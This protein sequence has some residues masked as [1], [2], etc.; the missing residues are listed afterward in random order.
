[1]RDSADNEGVRGLRHPSAAFLAAV[2]PLC[3]VAYATGGTLQRAAQLVVSLAGVAGIVA[4]TRRNRPNAPQAWYSAA[5]ALAVWLAG[6]ALHAWGPGPLGEHLGHLAGGAAYLV[7]V[8]LLTRAAVLAARARSG[9]NAR[10]DLLRAA[11]ATAPIVY[12]T[13]GLLVEDPVLTWLRT[14]AGAFPL[15]ATYPLAHALLLGAFL[16]LAQVPGAGRRVAAIP[17]VVL[18]TILAADLLGLTQPPL[19]A[20]HPV[21]FDLRWLVAYPALGAAALHPAM[22]KVTE[23][24]ARFRRPAHAAEIVGLML[25]PLTGPALLAWQDAHHEELSG[26]AAS[27]FILVITLL[28]G[29][30]MLEMVR[31]INA[32]AATDDLTRLPNRRALQACADTH[33]ADRR[34]R[35]AL[36]LLDLDRFKEVNDSLGHDT[37]DRLLVQVAARLR[38]TVRSDDLLARLGGDEFAVLL[39][40]AGREEAEHVAHALLASLEQPFDLGDLTVHAHGSVGI[41]LF[42]EHGTDLSTLLRRADAAMYRAKRQGRVHLHDAADDEGSSD[43]LRLAEELRAGLD[44]HELV[45]HYQPKLSLRTGLVCGV[46][47][48]V[49]WQHPTRGLLP[50]GAFL[51]RAEEVGL[52]PDLTS[53][54][55]G[56]ALDQA[57]RWAL[58]GRRL[59]VA[60]N[61]STSS[62]LD[63]DL[64]REI[65]AGL[66]GRDLP[67]SALRL[68]ITEEVLM[69]D[70]ARA[71]EVLTE[72]RRGGVTIAVDDFGTG[73]SSLAY[74]R[75]LP[76]DELKLDRSFIAPIEHDPR[77]AAL[78]TSVVTLAHSLGLAMVAEGVE[79]EATLLLLAQLGADQAQGYHLSRPLPAAELEAWLDARTAI[80]TGAQDPHGVSA[81]RPRP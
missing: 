40:G 59:E 42:P 64:P 24:G 2:L 48:L 62:L 3:V 26:P 29:A 51:E 18:G 5:A 53:E 17:A 52:M 8:L 80:T 56:L 43:R 69:A 45:V 63:V 78:V 50:P 61:L 19:L 25:A 12:V 60:V 58:D 74:L 6:D 35:R 55:L 14:H 31:F 1:L 67:P 47:A 27:I 71:R 75:D 33:L 72:L 13:W 21:T 76:I 54:V 66:A 30:R 10:S 15:E 11:I 22:V 16:R 34:T 46:E 4:G 28:V 39:D 57:A 79:D 36:L 49:R 41:A 20:G 70:R 9:E 38:S 37:G 7:A 32:Q 68:E 73:Y 23:Q 44:R 81:T 65:A 77:S